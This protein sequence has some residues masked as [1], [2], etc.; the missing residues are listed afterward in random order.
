[1]LGDSAVGHPEWSTVVPADNLMPYTSVNANN[2]IHSQKQRS[3]EGKDEPILI[4]VDDVVGNSA[5]QYQSELLSL[6]TTQRHHG[7][8][9]LLLSNTTNSIPTAPMKMNA[10][11]WSVK[12]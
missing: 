8:S 10:V 12:G 11:S 6:F 9:V 4:V 1:V 7:I 2:I 3:N 5:A